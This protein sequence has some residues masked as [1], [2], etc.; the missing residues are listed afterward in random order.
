MNHDKNRPAIDRLVGAAMLP[1]VICNVARARAANPA[2][3]AHLLPSRR[4]RWKNSRECPQNPVTHGDG[5]GTLGARIAVALA[6]WMRPSCPHGRSGQMRKRPPA[7][8]RLVYSR[9]YK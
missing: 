4:H 5:C 6:N 1:P 2:V 3:A 9:P 8:L 7:P